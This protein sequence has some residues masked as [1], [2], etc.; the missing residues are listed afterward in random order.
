MGGRAG[1]AKS[2]KHLAELEHNRD[3]VAN[4]EELLNTGEPS[5]VTPLT[6][7]L[8]RNL[9]EITTRH[10]ERLLYLSG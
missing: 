10:R 9:E 7:P 3:R 4:N 5:D 6:N 1:R 2:D 8:C